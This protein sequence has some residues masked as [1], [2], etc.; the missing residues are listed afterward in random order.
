MTTLSGIAAWAQNADIPLLRSTDLDHSADF[1]SNYTIDFG[2]YL[3]RTPD[4]VLRPHSQAQ[5]LACVQQ[6]CQAGIP[7]KVRGTGHS[8]GGQVLSSGGIIVDVRGLDRVLHI[9]RERCQVTVE[10]GATWLSLMQAL[11]PHGLRPLVLTDNLRMTLAGTLS[12]G[13]VGDTSLHHGLQANSVQRMTLVAP[14]GEVIDLD[15]GEAGARYVLCGRGQLGVIAAVCLQLVARPTTIWARTLRW[16]SLSTFLHDADRI[17]TH[18][19]YEF[20]RST[21][22]WPRGG[23]PFHIE[24]VAGN[25]CDQD[26][27]DSRPA[28]AEDE[29]LADAQSPLF[30]GDRL[31]HAAVDPIATWDY[32]C[33]NV[34]LVFPLPSGLPALQAVCE[35]VADSPWIDAFPEGSALMLLP[36]SPHLPLSPLPHDGT[37]VVLALRPRLHSQLAV[38]RSLP[39]L[40]HIAA[41]ALRSGARLYLASIDVTQPGV[42]PRDEFLHL[43][44]GA[45][46][47]EF[48]RLKLACDPQLLL[49]RGIFCDP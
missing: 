4:L 42:L 8:A 18:R 11:A 35:Q 47:A 48:Q 9:D 36:G 7:W 43:Q 6:I 14:P 1:R 23:Q 46:R 32:H 29:L 41:Q 16:G 26:G 3:T 15:A 45:A 38:E 44:F 34:E 10:A 20:F 22:H 21:L 5:L 37:Y 12:V 49:N 30:F 24:A 25:F 2:K 19:L 28:S 31:A 17:R 33:P 40:R 39:F 13:G 27:A